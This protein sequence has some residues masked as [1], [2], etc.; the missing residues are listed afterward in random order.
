MAETL[1]PTVAAIIAEDPSGIMAAKVNAVASKINAARELARRLQEERQAD[2]SGEGVRTHA[3]P[4]LRCPVCCPPLPRTS[5]TASVFSQFISV[6]S[7][8]GG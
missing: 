3:M 8:G 7:L 4:F 1:P 5:L 2:K 6:H